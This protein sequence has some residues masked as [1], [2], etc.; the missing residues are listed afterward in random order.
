MTE[1]NKKNH[2]LDMSARYLILLIFGLLGFYMIYLILTPLT[3]Y[4]SFFFLKILFNANLVNYQTFWNPGNV[5][6]FKG[7]YANI[8]SACVAGSA[9]YLLLILNLTTP[10]GLNKRFKSIIFLI[11][12]F[13]GVNVFRI[14]A[15]GVLLFK[16]YQYFDLTHQ[17]TWYFGSTLL[18]VLIWFTNTKLFKIETIPV[19]TDIKNIINLTKR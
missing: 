1:S 6:F 2:L 18:V 13:F 3:V 14:V 12:V 15:F 17:L 5:I 10:M 4:F 7:F 11:S 9:Y 19:Y 8:I 16:G